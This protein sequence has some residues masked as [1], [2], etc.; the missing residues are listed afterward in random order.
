MGTTRYRVVPSTV[1]FSHRRLISTVGDQLR[2]KEEE[3]ETCSATR[4]S[5]PVP[6]RDLSP[7]SDS[8]PAGNSFLSCGEKERRY[9]LYVSLGTGYRTIPY[10]TEINSVCRYGKLSEESQAS[11]L[12]LL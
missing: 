2:E 6:P 3:G 12:S 4:C 9:A 1:D 8:S 11:L 5:S 7:A 10:R